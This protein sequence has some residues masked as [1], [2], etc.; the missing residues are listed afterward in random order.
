[1]TAITG[2]TRAGKKRGRGIRRER[3]LSVVRNGVPRGPSQGPRRRLAR[4][5]QRLQQHLCG[6]SRWGAISCRCS[7]GT[8]TATSPAFRSRVAAGDGS[9]RRT[10]DR[11]SG[12]AER[13]SGRP[14]RRTGKTRRARCAGRGPRDGCSTTRRCASAAAAGCRSSTTA[15][16]SPAGARASA[17]AARS[18]CSATATAAACTG[19]AP[20]SRGLDVLVVASSGSGAWRARQAQHGTVAPRESVHGAGSK[21]KGPPPRAGPDL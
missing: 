10:A 11:S 21:A 1:M 9:T 19:T 2:T 5:V 6:Q 18:C 3:D 16:A 13:A 20:D 14:A 15:P 8:S 4:A 12:D 17:A 7:A